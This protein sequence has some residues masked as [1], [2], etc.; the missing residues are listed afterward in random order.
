MKKI[1]TN[2]IV[3]NLSR[4]QDSKVLCVRY[5]TGLSTSIRVVYTF[6]PFLL[7]FIYVDGDEC[8]VLFFS[9]A[10]WAELKELFMNEEGG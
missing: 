8:K 10:S 1:H 3:Y 7:F 4:Q 2:E 5:Q 6:P 9:T